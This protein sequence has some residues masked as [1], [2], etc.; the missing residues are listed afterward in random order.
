MSAKSQHAK[1]MKLFKE[2]HGVQPEI[3]DDIARVVMEP[4]TAFR[5]GELSGVM[6]VALSDKQEYIHQFK[7]NDRPAL[8][9]SSDGKQAFIL[10]GGYV[11]TDRGFEG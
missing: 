9:V 10:G 11:F 7:K 2:F 4:E 5:V 6:Y 8:F 1:A 3:P